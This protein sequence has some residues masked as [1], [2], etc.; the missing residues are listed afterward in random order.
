[1]WGPSGFSGG[2]AYEAAMHIARS[3]GRDIHIVE[4]EL[5]LKGL[6]GHGEQGVAESDG[7]VDM[8]DAPRYVYVCIY[9]CICLCMYI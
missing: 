3:R 2:F 9:A 1:M 7:D 8:K 6:I 4:N 5:E